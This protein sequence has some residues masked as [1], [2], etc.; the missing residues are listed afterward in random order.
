MEIKPA[1]IFDLDG[2]LVDTV[3]AHYLGWSIVA[4]KLG[5]PFTRE[6]N[7]KFRGIPR[8]KVIFKLINQT[9]IEL[10]E[11]QINHLMDLKVKFYREYIRKN[12]E[13]IQIKGVKSLL[14]TLKNNGFPLG[15]ASA[16]KNAYFLLKIADL[17][18]YFDI[19]SDGHFPGK[20]K[21]EP[22]QL[23]FIASRLNRDPQN[24][25]VVEDSI[26]GLQ[27]AKRAGMIS[28]AVGKY[29]TNF[30]GYDFYYDSLNAF[31]S[32]KFIETINTIQ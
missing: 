29:V 16:S 15:L 6:D 24:C 26:A 19:I 25:I 28:I 27:A 20:P 21:P 17:E 14:N 32:Q 9:N 2:V 30:K 11:D 10:D 5:I 1:V 13:K 31:D 4:R 7:E 12:A 22:G 23:L 18:S 3:D 8:K